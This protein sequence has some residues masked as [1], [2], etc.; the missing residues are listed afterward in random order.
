MAHLA[1]IR[2]DIA[3]DHSWTS[4]GI[5]RPTHKHLEHFKETLRYAW[6][7]IDFCHRHVV[8]HGLTLHDG[9]EPIR[10]YDTMLP[11]P[12][13][14]TLLRH[15]SDPLVEYGLYAMLDMARQ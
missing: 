11:S 10:P 5:A 15:S 8:S 4:Q 13:T 2:I 14:A 9:D 1:R 6:A 12:R 3:F 7:T